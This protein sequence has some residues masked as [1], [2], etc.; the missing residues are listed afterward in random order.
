MIRQFVLQELEKQKA[1]LAVDQEKEETNSNKVRSPTK[2]KSKLTNRSFRENYKRMKKFMLDNIRK[3]KKEYSR[4]MDNNRKKA[5]RDNLD[6]NQIKQS[7]I[8]EKSY[9]KL[10]VIT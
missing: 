5:K 1:K 9:R 6:D 10:C 8:Y 4:K 2:R 3:K 7:R